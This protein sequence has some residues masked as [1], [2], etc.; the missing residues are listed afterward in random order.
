[1]GITSFF[2]SVDRNFDVI[3]YL[4]EPYN[5]VDATHFLIDF[6][7]IIHNVSSEMLS[8]INNASN[9]SFTFNSLSDFEPQ[10]IIQVKEAIKNLLKN[11][12][13]SQNINY[14][15]LAID[16]VP[17]FAKMMEQKKRRYIGDLM[18]KLMKE[19]E[20]PIDWSKTNISPGTKFMDDMCK[21]LKTESFIN[22]C[23]KICPNLTGML[24]SDVYNPGEGEMKIMKCLRGL[25]GTKNK[26]CVYSPDSDMILLLMILDIDVSLLRFDQQTSKIKKKKIY[27][28]IDI[29][30]FKNELIN[31]CRNR[32]D[33]ITDERLLINEIIYI[34]TL[35]GDDFLPKLESVQV[36]N[37]INS[38]ID[39]YLLTL[40]EVGNIL[41]RHTG[42]VNNKYT[43]NH[44]NLKHFF[45]LLTKNEMK[46]INRNFYNSKF[47]NY[48]YAKDKNFHLDL[49]NFKA[50][51]NNI[52]LKFIVKSNSL[53][54]T[55]SICTPLNAATC[56]DVGFF[57]DFLK[58]SLDKTYNYNMEVTEYNGNTYSTG[59]RPSDVNLNQNIY[60]KIIRTIKASNNSS[61]PYYNF[62]YNISK[63]IDGNTLYHTL[64][65]DGVLGSSLFGRRSEEFKKIVTEFKSMYYLKIKP[66]ELLED[67]IL[68]LYLQPLQLPFVNFSLDAPDTPIKL[69]V[70]SFELKDHINKLKRDHLLDEKNK[71]GKLEYIITNKLEGYDKLFNPEHS[72][73]KK[74]L[75]STSS[76]NST[77]FPNKDIKTVINKY[78]EGFE[79]VLNYYF[80]DKTDL[81]WYYPYGRI[82]LLSDIVKHYPT[83]FT[84]LNFNENRNFNPLESIIFI[85]PLEPGYKLTFFPESVTSETINLIQQFMNSNRQF[86]LPLSEI[87]INL[88][89]DITSLPDLLDCSTSIFLS[90]CH[91]KL[92]DQNNDPELFIKNFRKIIPEIKQQLQNNTEFKCIN[93]GLSSK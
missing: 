38:I 9:L 13:I 72:F 35:F 80:N 48:R 32:V 70:R 16:G 74:K 56:I 23:K 34:F 28:L 45:D 65:G 87:N 24:V 20:L 63:I 3:T 60:E 29:N 55:T 57:Y 69:Q 64:Y 19:V 7:S 41:T 40:K 21:E 4:E 22:E 84:E 73:Y 27:N 30:K 78:I 83:T 92:L 66:S 51:I 37:D 90:K 25:T 62:I 85:T 36:A 77:F 71:R 89:K 1:M 33:T 6:N 79:W 88:T 44:N 31:Y 86:F 82:P 47:R 5:K 8:D 43:L 46:D 75:E 67:L 12:F 2:S 18:N 26:I 17:S 54:R 59:N 42:D 10:L 15:M 93:L 68:Y 53:K 58:S 81:L 52:I 14:V 61:T 39:N 76:Y 49:Y 50:D 11:N 91:Y